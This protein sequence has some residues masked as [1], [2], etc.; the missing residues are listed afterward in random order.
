[1]KSGQRIRP[2]PKLLLKARAENCKSNAAKNGRRESDSPI[3]SQ[4]LPN[5]SD[6][7]PSDAE[8]VEKRGLLRRIRLIEPTSGLRAGTALPHEKER[9][10]RA[11]IICS[12]RQY[13]VEEPGAVVP[14]AG[15]CAGA[16]GN[17]RP[18]RGQNRTQVKTLFFQFAVE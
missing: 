11:V 15:I 8:G 3:V 2:T 1:V 5:K 12:T 13:F 7:A 14:H 4:K 17:S 18:Y 10:G 6:G 16:A 9:N